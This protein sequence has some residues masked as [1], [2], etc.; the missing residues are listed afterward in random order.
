METARSIEASSSD[1]R[2]YRLDLSWLTVEVAAYA[3]LALLALM[4]RLFLLDLWPLSEAE[5]PVALSALRAARGETPNA[6]ARRVEERTS[7]F[8]HSYRV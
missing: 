2:V 5:L 3:G 8:G 6:S 4:G 7:R 1:R